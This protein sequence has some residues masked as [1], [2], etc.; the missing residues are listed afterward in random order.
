M[1]PGSGP[2]A[3]RDSDFWAV[4]NNAGVVVRPNGQPGGAVPRAE[5]ESVGMYKVTFNRDVRSLCSYQA[6]IGGTGN[7]VPGEESQITRVLLPPTPT[8]R[9]YTFA[10]PTPG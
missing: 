3:R 6:T 4:V 10:P 7:A 8:T 9:P 5:R 1:S 2:C